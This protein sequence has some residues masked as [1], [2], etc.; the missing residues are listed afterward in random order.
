MPPLFWGGGGPFSRTGPRPRA[1]GPTLT[2][3]TWLIVKIVKN[4][5]N[6]LNKKFKLVI[7]S[8]LFMKKIPIEVDGFFKQ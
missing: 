1:G 2:S 8:L 3:L 6:Y 4:T 7:L 5:C